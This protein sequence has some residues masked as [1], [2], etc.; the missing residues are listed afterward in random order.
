MFLV[1]PF[2]FLLNGMRCFMY[3]YTNFCFYLTWS[4]FCVIIISDLEENRED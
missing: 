4:R 3:F 2:L 1:L